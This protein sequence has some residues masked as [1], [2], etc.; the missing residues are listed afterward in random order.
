MATP[1]GEF[2]GDRAADLAVDAGHGTD[3]ILDHAVRVG[4]VDVETVELAVGREVDAGLGLDVE[5]DARG[6]DDGL[7]GGERGG[8]VWNRIG[9]DGGGEDAWFSHKGGWGWVGWE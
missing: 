8:P 2:L 6:V 7:L 3:E 1:A 4:V 5:H 9:G